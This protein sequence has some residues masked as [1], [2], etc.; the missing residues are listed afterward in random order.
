MSLISDKNHFCEGDHGEQYLCQVPESRNFDLRRR[1]QLGCED[2]YEGCENIYE[3]LLKGR[4][5]MKT[6]ITLLQFDPNR[7]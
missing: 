7:Y 5:N 1:L 2:V 3:D 6:Q 4:W